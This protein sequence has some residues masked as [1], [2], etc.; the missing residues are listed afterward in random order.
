MINDLLEAWVMLSQKMGRE[1][2]EQVFEKV[3]FIFY[4]W[5]GV[6]I[7]LGLPSGTSG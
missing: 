1:R 2:E 6:L 3:Y 4:I 5:E 7:A